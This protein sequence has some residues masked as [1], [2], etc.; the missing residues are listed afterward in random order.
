MNTPNPRNVNFL[1]QFEN[2][3][4]ASTFR[5]INGVLHFFDRYGNEVLPQNIERSVS[6]DRE[7]KDPKIQT[8][9]TTKLN[10]SS[11]NGLYELTQYDDVIVIDTNSKETA[12][13]KLS[14]CCAMILQFRQEGEAIRI[15]CKERKVRLLEFYNVQ[16][17]AE[18]LSILLI[19]NECIV[20]DGYW[21]RRPSKNRAIINDSAISLHEKISAREIPIFQNIFLP[22]GFSIHYAS[23]DLKQEVLN[24]IISTCDKQA[25]EHYVLMQQNKTPANP[26]N[27]LK[28]DPSI[29]FRGFDLPL[30]EFEC[31]TKGLQLQKDSRMYLYGIKTEE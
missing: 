27:I 16:G 12:N 5:T 2:N 31:V 4:K 14:I 9:I 7:N 13:G 17:N 20:Q 1:I 3:H 11:I 28:Y 23:A 30:V 15:S 18:L 24:K 22:R 21:D 6:Y 29:L 26:L 10:N 8:R 19:A 25:N